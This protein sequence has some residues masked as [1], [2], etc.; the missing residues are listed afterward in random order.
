MPDHETTAERLVAELA[1]VNLHSASAS[2]SDESLSIVAEQ[3]LLAQQL[4]RQAEEQAAKERERAE[5]LRTWDAVRYWLEPEGSVA[6][7]RVQDDRGKT[8]EPLVAAVRAITGLNEALAKRGLLDRLASPPA[9]IEG[10]KL[11]AWRLA[12]DI[13]R[14]APGHSAEAGMLLSRVAGLP[15]APQVRVW[16]CD[17]FRR[18]VEEGW[19]GRDQPMSETFVSLSRQQSETMEGG[20]TVMPTDPCET[21]RRRQAEVQEMLEREK[22]EEARRAPAAELSAAWDE[23]AQL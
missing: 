9:G 19:N 13:L 4:R 17:G 14:L 10:E 11:Q 15:L 12:T 20:D 21:L 6:L 8:V 2:L 1:H 3:E 7:H 16:L 5:W 22:A 23:L 18:V